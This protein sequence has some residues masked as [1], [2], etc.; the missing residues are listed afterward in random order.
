MLPPNRISS[1]ASSPSN[2]FPLTVSIS[3]IDAAVK[4]RPSP[5][6]NRMSEFPVVMTVPETSG[7][8]NVRFDVNEGTLKLDRYI[9]SAVDSRKLMDSSRHFHLPPAPP[10]TAWAYDTVVVVMIIC[11]SVKICA[12]T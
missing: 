8:N 7:K 5:A 3:L 4:S 2:V 12:T 1:F 10:L 6:P 9:G 11:S